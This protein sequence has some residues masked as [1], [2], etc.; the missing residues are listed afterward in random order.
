MLFAVTG[1]TGLVGNNVIRYLVGMGVSVKAIV[2]PGESLAPLDGLNVDVAYADITKPAEIQEALKGTDI[3]IHAA[4]LVS[5]TEASE[6]RL[7]AVNVGRTKNVIDACKQNDVSKFVYI[8]SI[9]ALPSSG[10]GP[11]KETKELSVKYVHGA[12]AKS[13]VLATLLAFQAAEEGLPTVVLHPT[14]IVGPYD[15]RGSIVGKLI[16]SALSGKLKWY[17]SGG[18][19]FVDA[20]DVAKAAYLAVQ[21]GASGEN[22]I[23]A[24]SYISIRDFLEGCLTAAG[25]PFDL[26]EIPYAVALA[27]SPFMEWYDVNRG[28]EPQM[29][30]YALRT[31]RSKSDIDCSKIQKECGFVPMPM[32]DTV[33]DVSKWYQSMMLEHV[34]V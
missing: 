13:K 31:L 20:R 7:R 3:V 9:H 4:G 12:Y 18:Y 23:V 17:V 28:K 11:I 10:E 19:D 22:Y 27:V 15:F 2:Q 21:K 24:G 33:R 5:I 30:V 16:M 8:S 32:E 25:K 1:S 14:G 26:K 34:L 29:S 6:N